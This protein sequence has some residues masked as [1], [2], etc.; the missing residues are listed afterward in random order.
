MIIEKAKEKS[1]MKVYAVS[2]TEGI[3]GN[4][5]FNGVYGVFSTIDKA[6]KAIEEYTSAWNDNI[7]D[8]DNDTVTWHYFTSQGTWSI[9][10]I[11]LDDVGL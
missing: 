10:T 8:F 11:E 3:R 1:K 7:L 6:I 9:D 4:I 5:W 2:W